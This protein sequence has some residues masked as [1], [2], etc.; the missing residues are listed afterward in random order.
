MG[1]LSLRQSASFNDPS[2]TSNPDSHVK[3][4][5]FLKLQGFAIIRMDAF[6]YVRAC[7]SYEVHDSTIWT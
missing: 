5:S 3:I 6:A 4:C 2:P 7:W 1:G